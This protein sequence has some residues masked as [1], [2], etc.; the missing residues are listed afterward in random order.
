MK[1]LSHSDRDTIGYNKRASEA[2][3]RAMK[4]FIYPGNDDDPSSSV[5]CRETI[6]SN[7]ATRKSK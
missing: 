7:Y 6:D 3:E 1:I 5:I 2:E 4:D